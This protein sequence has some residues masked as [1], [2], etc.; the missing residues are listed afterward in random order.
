M[1]KS[2]FSPLYEHFRRQLVAWREKA[3]MT[4]R[5]LAEELGREHSFVSRIELGERRLDVVE[6]YWVAK[7]LGLDPPRIAAKLM[8]ELTQFSHQTRRDHGASARRFARGGD[9][10]SQAP[11]AGSGS[12]RRPPPTCKSRPSQG[13]VAAGFSLLSLDLLRRYFLQDGSPNPT[14][15]LLGNPRPTVPAAAAPRPHARR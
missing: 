6:F 13:S 3:G 14:M 7:A 2:T 1:E 15:I 10:S 12:A 4:Q 5:D 11:D 8:R 9:S